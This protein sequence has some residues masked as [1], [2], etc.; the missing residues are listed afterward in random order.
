M[1]KF[2]D[3]LRQLAE[4][5]PQP[6]GFR[7]RGAASDKPKI[8]LV[9]AVAEAGAAGGIAGADAMLLDPEGVPESKVEV[10]WGIRVGAAAPPDG[11]DFVVFPT[12]TP[13]TLNLKEGVGKILAVHSSLPSEVVR[14]LNGVSLDAVLLLAAEDRGRSLTWIELVDF[15]RFAT[16]LNKPLLVEVPTSITGA[17]IGQVW[18]AGAA[19]IVVRITSGQAKRVAELREAISGLAVPITAR[20]SRPVVRAPIAA[21]SVRTEDDDDDDDDE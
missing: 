21:S 10:P 20:N 15:H 7:P 8:Q 16:V 14:A 11:C 17:E 13:L 3:R 6:I 1:S 4:G 5:A 9:V 2:V 18:Q 19:G 12:E